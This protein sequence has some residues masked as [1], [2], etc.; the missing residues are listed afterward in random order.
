VTIE[1]WRP[2]VTEELGYYVY[3][4]ID[5]ASQRVFY[6][7]KGKEDRCFQHLVEAR[8]TAAGAIGDYAKL[9]KIREIEDRGQ[10]VRIDLLRYGLDE[11][12]AIAVE[13]A[14]IDLLDRTDGHSGAFVDPEWEPL[15]N[16]IR[17]Q[18]KGF[19]LT[20]A[21]EVNAKYGAEPK[22]VDPEHRVMLIRVAKQFHPDIEG[23]DLYHAT[24]QWW[25][26]GHDRRDG[27]PRS[28]E[29]AFAVYRGVVRAVYR[30]DRW[31]APTDT[32]IA[33]DPG[34]AG[35]WAFDGELDPAMTEQYLFADV[36][37]WLPEGAQN[38]IR[39]VNCPPSSDGGADMDVDSY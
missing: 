8:A 25:V 23:Q 21:D 32:E 1:G 19:G 38:P 28:P 27:G 13:A 11:D 16:R 35:R 24:R 18:A 39:Y 30:I 12:T 6:V 33:E 15:A 10:Q 14:A 17:G 3:L 37:A 29:W 20:T 34:S 36:S 9:A 7:G 5:P 26:V 2:R 31:V 4:L 22:P